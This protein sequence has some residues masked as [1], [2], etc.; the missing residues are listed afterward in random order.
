MQFNCFVAHYH[1]FGK[2]EVLFIF[3]LVSELDTLC[4]DLFLEC[5][6]FDFYFILICLKILI[7]F[8]PLMV[9]TMAIGK[10]VCDFFF[11]VHWL[12]ED[13]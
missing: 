6:P 1:T 12:L 13:C 8:L 9:R 5:Y 10:L 4:L 7:L 11:K 3:Q 2:I